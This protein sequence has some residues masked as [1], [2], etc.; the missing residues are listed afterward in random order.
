MKFFNV[1]R[2]TLFKNQYRYKAHFDLFVFWDGKNEF[3]NSAADKEYM[4]NVLAILRERFFGK[5][6]NQGSVVY[7]DDLDCIFWIRLLFDEKL[8]KIEKIV[9]DDDSY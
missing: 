5:F 1:K 4:E 7:T 3:W 8:L 2:N 6:C 9:F